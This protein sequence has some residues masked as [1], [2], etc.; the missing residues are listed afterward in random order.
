M[1]NLSRRDFAR[2]LALSGSASLLPARAFGQ[3]SI[4]F[5]ELGFSVKPYKRSFFAAPLSGVP[6][7]LRIFRLS[8]V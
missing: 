3:P 8:S 2:F 5:E 4:A 7:D 6:E 1:A